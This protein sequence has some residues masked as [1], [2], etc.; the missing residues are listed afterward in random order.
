MSYCEIK[1]LVGGSRAGK[2]WETMD[3]KKKGSQ[4]WTTMRHN[5]VLFPDPY[6]PLPKSVKVLYEGKPLK[7]DATDT[8]NKF[9]LTAEEVAVFYAQKL[10]A[11]DRLCAKNK[12]RASIRDDKVFKKNFWTDWKTILGSRSPIKKLSDVDFGPLQKYIVERSENKK[13]LQKSLTKTQ[14]E[15]EK[16]EK[17]AVKDIYGYAVVD[18]VRIPLGNYMVEPPTIFAGHASPNRGKLKKR[19]KPT[20]ITINVSKTYIP[21]CISHGKHCKW[22]QVDQNKKVTWIARWEDPVTGGK[23]YVWL[24][25]IESHFVCGDDMVKFDKARKLDKNIDKIRKHYTRDMKSSVA[26]TKQLAIAVYFLDLLAIRPG[27]EKDETKEANTAGLTTLKC[28]NITFK[29]S[30][31]IKIS[32]M[33][34]SSIKFDK[35][36][37]IDHAAYKYLKKSC[38]DSKTKA[39]FPD[40]D[41]NTLN[42][43]LKTLLTGLTAKVFRTWKASSI[44]QKELGKSVVGVD[45]STSSKKLTYDRVNIEVAKALNHKKMGDNDATTKKLKEK[46]KILKQKLNDANTV[47]QKASTK[48][49]IEKNKAKLEEAMFNLSTSTSKVNYLDPRIT[50]SWAKNAQVPIEKLYNKQQLKKF[51]WAMDIDP[52]WKF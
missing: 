17:E 40:V 13:H 23:K 27:T 25:R 11:D 16:A 2:W 24:N 44:L 50:V 45:E 48:A 8:L 41:S 46:E 22:G 36:V 1:K 32:F 52:Q 42:D 26:M 15:D 37:R 34:K 31:E 20:D 7:L 10:E 33:G 29:A 51:I 47:K 49:A 38:G 35:T 39:L 14:K 12:K 4:M 19:M 28:G 3:H 6:E 9:N 18:D 21:K 43:Y 30:D 5:G